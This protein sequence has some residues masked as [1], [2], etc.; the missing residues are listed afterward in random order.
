MNAFPRPAILGLAPLM[1]ACGHPQPRPAPATLADCEAL[2]Q[3][4]VQARQE[5][6]AAERRSH[7]A[8]KAFVPF[9]IAARH[10]EAKSEITAGEARIAA[11]EK[12]AAARD[13]AP[14]AAGG[15]TRLGEG[16]RP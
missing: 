14:P 8:W 4:L 7:E 1:V 15:M 12:E 16:S 3:A 9:A 11:L 10:A 2:T 13:C 6:A 5:R